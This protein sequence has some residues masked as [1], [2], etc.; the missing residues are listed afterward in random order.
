M[1]FQPFA[2]SLIANNVVANIWETYETAAVE[3]GNEPDRSEFKIARAV[4]LADS[5]KEAQKLG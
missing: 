5:T 1:G 3:A 2:H 4:F